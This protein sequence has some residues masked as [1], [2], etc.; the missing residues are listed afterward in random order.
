MVRRIYCFTL[1]LC[2]T[3]LKLQAQFISDYMPNY[4]VFLQSYEY[5]VFSQAVFSGVNKYGGTLGY[6]INVSKSNNS[7]KCLIEIK[8]EKELQSIKY[9]VSELSLQVLN[10]VNETGSLSKA[11]SE[12]ITLLKSVTQ[13]LDYALANPNRKLIRVA[14]T[15]T[16]N[17]SLLYLT[18]KEGEISLLT[19]GNKD[20]LKDFFNKPIIFSGWVNADRSV[21]FVDVIE[22]KLHT[23]EIFTMSKCPFGQQAISSLLNYL[24]KKSPPANLK[25][26]VHYIFY[27]KQNT[28]FTL[29][30]EDEII[31]NLVQITIRDKFFKYFLS[32]L[33]K[34]IE[35]KNDSWENIALSVGLKKDDI[36]QIKQSIDESRDSII[37]NEYDY[38]ANKNG[39]SDGSP[40]FL[41]EGQVIKDIKKLRDFENFEIS[42]ESCNSH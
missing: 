13:K 15:V 32:Y 5:P 18:T 9:C 7:L 38:V 19:G 39:I 12:R 3:L 8:D 2:L 37:A 14:G 36:R 41:W 34:R 42:S 29:H 17:D 25:L 21:E 6:D 23:L 16:Q 11:T 28:Y 10:E 26:E 31:E 1:L 4:Q 40:T 30:G 35:N 33:R 22:Q 24:D 27:K 20:K